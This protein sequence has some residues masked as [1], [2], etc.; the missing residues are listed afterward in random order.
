M[1]VSCLVHRLSGASEGAP[2]LSDRTIWDVWC[3][4]LGPPYG[5][6]RY[7]ILPV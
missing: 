3:L 5:C 4:L 1:G 6:R 7:D 2:S